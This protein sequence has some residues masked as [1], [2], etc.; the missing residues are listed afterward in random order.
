MN[1]TL[2]VTILILVFLICS[3]CVSSF[4]IDG[5]YKGRII[6]AQ[7]NQPI[8]GAVIDATWCRV[9][10]NAGGGTGVYYD[11][12][13]TIS[14]KAGEFSIP[15]MGLLF[16][17]TIDEATITIFKAG[18][19]GIGPGPWGAFDDKYLRQFNGQI[20]R[21]NGDLIFRLKRLSMEERRNR[22]GVYPFP[23][24][25]NNKTKLFTIENNKEQLEIGKPS[26]N[27]IPIE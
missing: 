10:P 12:R 25:P 11:N 21:D 8:E 14:D 27:P 1:K 24:A 9:Y 6:D 20:T 18:Y 19:D 5:P 22:R 3:G 16:L 4:R 7:T 2:H 17:S 15:G 26:S 13:E 23:D